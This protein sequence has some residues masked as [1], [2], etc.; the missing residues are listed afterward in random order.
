MNVPLNFPRIALAAVAA[1]IASLGV[2]F[3]VNDFL[4]ADILAANQAAMR[5]EADLTAN[6]PVGFVLLLVGFFAFTYAFAKGHEGTDGVMEGIRFG[7]LVGLV[8]LGFANIW[9]WVVYPIDGAM[10][11]AIVISS[12]V[13]MALYGAIVGA[14]YKPLGK[15]AA[16]R[17]PAL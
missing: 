17:A 13:E 2:G 1:W 8:V 15:T 7:V 10:A 14:I 12:I 5:P 6:L 4:L 9:Q 3:F 16:Q 11:T